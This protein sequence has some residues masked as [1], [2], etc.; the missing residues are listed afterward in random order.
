VQAKIRHLEMIQGVIA[1]MASNSFALKGWAVTLVTALIALL[2]TVG[3][4]V[5]ILIAYIPLLSFWGLDSYYLLQEKRYRE[6]YDKV[7][8]LSEEEIDF[9]MNARL[10]GPR[11]CMGFLSCLVSN[12]QL[13]FYLPLVFISTAVTLIICLC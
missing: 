5:H 2:H 8:E 1:R 13:W 6:L 12:T 11:G 3:G 4:T 7:R 10:E 9:C